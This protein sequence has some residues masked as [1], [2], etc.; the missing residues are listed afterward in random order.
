MSIVPVD[1]KYIGELEEM[2][3]EAYGPGVYDWWHANEQV[4]IMMYENGLGFLSYRLKIH[5]IEIEKL[6][7]ARN[8]RRLGYGS[9][10]LYWLIERARKRQI[11]MLRCVLPLSNIQGSWFLAH[12][13]FDSKLLP[14]DFIQ[15]QR[16]VVLR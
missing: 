2:D 10:M 4:T 15:F 5:A 11:N 13:G 12:H 14:K 9:E 8:V 7:V 6:V 3:R 16:L 1:A